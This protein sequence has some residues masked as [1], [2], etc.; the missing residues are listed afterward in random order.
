MKTVENYV[1]K[2]SKLPQIELIITYE[3]LKSKNPLLVHKA[4]GYDCQ[5]LHAQLFFAC[6]SEENQQGYD[7]NKG[8]N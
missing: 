3:P 5:F 1:K 8:E 6:E 4:G 2:A 7:G